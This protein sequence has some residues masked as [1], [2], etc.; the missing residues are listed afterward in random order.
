MRIDEKAMNWVAPFG[1]DLVSS[2]YSLAAPLLLIELHANPV[3]LGLI[4]SVTSAV[5]MSL[6]HRMGPYSDRLGR[7]RL[8][9]MAP[10]LFASSCLIAAI[11]GRVKVVLALSAIN[12]LCL[13]LF[14]PPFQAW[15]AERQTGTGVA[16]DIG[17]LNLAWT[18]AFVVGPVISGFLFSLQPRLPFFFAASMALLLFSLSYGS[19][20]DRRGTS[21]RKQALEPKEIH[22]GRKDVLYIAWIANFMSW[23]LLANARYQ[24]PKLARDLGESPQVVGILVGCLG[25]SL[26]LGF[27]V[28][29]ASLL[30]HFRKRYLFGAQALGAAG[31]L[32]LSFAS[33]ALWLGL[34]LT[35]IGVSASVTY[36]SSLLYAIEFSAE[37]GKGAGWHESILS[38]GAVLGPLLGGVAAYY[39]GLRA[40]YWVCFF[41]L[42]AA[43][44]AEGLLVLRRRLSVRGSISSS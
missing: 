27:F 38:F 3:E 19:I 2:L 26:F 8:I 35:L 25:F 10:L 41:F 13:S 4:G 14:W 16:R 32:I 22:M 1:M 33:Q 6:A 36:Y 7:R 20:H 18:A 11:A 44:V 12:G 28:L 37:K 40:P 21:Q 43:A 17:T 39:S 42:L 29:R 30:W 15:V 5:H 24:F 34:A 9:L 23:F 31:V